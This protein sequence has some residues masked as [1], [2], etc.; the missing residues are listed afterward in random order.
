MR[1]HKKMA[2]VYRTNIDNKGRFKTTTHLLYKLF[3]D[4]LLHIDLED[5]KKVLRL[6]GMDMICAEVIN[7]LGKIGFLCQVMYW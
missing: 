4:L 6:E 7:S 3:S 5:S 2:V 1:S